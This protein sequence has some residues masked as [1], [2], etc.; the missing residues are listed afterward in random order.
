M[1]P[2]YRKGPTNLPKIWPKHGF[3]NYPQNCPQSCPK[4]APTNNPQTSPPRDK[5]VRGLQPQLMGWVG[6]S[7][8]GVGGAVAVI[9]LY[10]LTSG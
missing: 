5:P 8:A 2:A 6:E 9:E 10:L 1:H 7:H 4:R 3:N